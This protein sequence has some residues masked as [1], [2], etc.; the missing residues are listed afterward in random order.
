MATHPGHSLPFP[1]LSR[2]NPMEN[3]SVYRSSA[4]SGKTYT[5]VKEYITLALASQAYFRHILAITFTNKAANEMKQRIVTALSHLAAPDEN[6]QGAIIRFMLPDLEKATGF[7][8]EEISSRATAVLSRILHD[9]DDFSVRTIDSFVSGIIR[10]FAHD[11]HLPVDF[12]IGMD[13]DLLLD[14]AVSRVIDKAGTDM[15]LTDILVEFT[16]VKAED[17]KSFNIE[18]D[19]KKVAEYLFK[20]GNAVFLEALKDISPKRIQELAADCIR[21][22]IAFENQVAAEATK[23]LK[24]ITDGGIEQDSFSGGGYGLGGYFRKLADGILAKPKITVEKTFTED[25]WFS[26]R[27]DS[28]QKA[29]I[30]AIKTE[31][32]NLYNSCIDMLENGME[33]YV[34]L[35]LIARNIYQTGVIHA[36]SRE[37]N[38]ISRDQ[39]ILHI[40]EFNK[41]ITG[42]ILNEPVPFIYER[43]GEKY[44]NYL[45]DEFQDTSELQWK[46]LLPLIGDSLA[47]ARYNLVVGD[48]KQAIYRFRNGRVEQFMMLPDLPADFEEDVFEDAAQSMQANYSARNLSSNFRSQP[49]IIGFNNRFFRFLSGKLGE[50]FRPIYDELEQSVSAGKNGGMVTI[51]FV[52]ADAKAD[53]KLLNAEKVRG[54]IGTLREDGFKLSDIA[55]LTRTNGEG[56][57]IA[58]DL[59]SN[60][61]RVVSAEA[62]LLVS[63]PEVN[64]MVGVIRHLHDPSDLIAV[65]GIL[66]GLIRRGRIQTPLSG[67]FPGNYPQRFPLAKILAEEGIHFDEVYLKGLPVYD[68]CEEI[69]RMLELDQENSNVYVQF[70]LE[71]VNTLS[72]KKGM[73]LSDLLESWDE[74]KSKLSVVVPEGI[75]AVRI[76]TIHKSKGLEFPV[77]ILPMAT[78]YQKSTKDDLWVSLSDD[79]LPGLPVALLP[80]SKQLE[81]TRFAGAYQSERESS[82]LDLINTIYVAFTRPSER[83]YIFTSGPQKSIGNNLPSFLDEF[84]GSAMPEP[85]KEGNVY[86]FGSPVP[87]SGKP[88]AK[89]AETPETKMI[90]V[91]WRER[92]RISRSAPVFRNMAG[93]RDKQ[94]WGNLVHDTLA[95]LKNASDISDASAVMAR[96][97]RLSEEDTGRLIREVS[98]TVSHPK[99]KPYFDPGIQIK[100]ESGILTPSGEVFRPDRVVFTHSETVIMEF[101]TGIADPAHHKQL[102]NYGG[103]LRDMGYPGIRTF[104]I[105]IGDQVSVEEL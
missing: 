70:F 4:G 21:F 97:N 83:L 102:I 40:S 101:K 85:H 50:A 41:R 89:A 82:L 76:M 43:I 42:I 38:S 59:M 103:L 73:H 29:S 20:E 26:G 58:R 93:Q 68:L 88:E 80:T 9:Y 24:L 48:G 22:R 39:N 49:E 14:E 69:L 98:E 25:K 65:T 87:G 74:K 79:V 64:L 13:S 2:V 81:E 104:L 12:E 28:A 77:V 35:G 60:G 27:A 36:V 57:L 91:P 94:S 47:N 10:T 90:S 16:E 95:S 72:A 96:K 63:S 53:F 11:L 78:A 1:Y 51:E 100:P 30:T 23:A 75:D 86:R 19:L 46:N 3:F 55:V 8:P 32:T 31:L 99:L 61:I 67:Y 62:L 54:L 45:I 37:L 7:S 33:R 66:T 84:V 92:I 34:L 18:S 6:R 17:E 15:E 44:Y 56:S 5:L 71:F 105:Y 52:A